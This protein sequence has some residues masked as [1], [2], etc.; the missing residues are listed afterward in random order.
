[1]AEVMIRLSLPEI[2]RPGNSIISGVRPNQNYSTLI[3][4]WLIVCG[5]EMLANRR[6]QDSR[7]G[8]AMHQKLYYCQASFFVKKWKKRAGLELIRRCFSP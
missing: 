1:M 7:F 5:Y 6:A 8:L 4:Y 2:K 3:S